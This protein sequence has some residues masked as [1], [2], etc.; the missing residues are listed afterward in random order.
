MANQFGNYL[1]QKIIEVSSKEELKIIID[2]VSLKAQEIS[3]S[4][5]GTRAMQTLVETLAKNIKGLEVQCRKLIKEIDRDILQLS[6]H[7]NG[8][9]VIQ[10]FLNAFRS[11][12]QPAD[13]DLEGAEARS[14]FTQFIFEACMRH[15]EEIGTHKHGCCV[16]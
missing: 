16:M 8:N 10:A 6:T 13:S 2:A 4:V 3:L 12:D 7:V 1:C 5:H 9:H 14:T 15:C 11:S